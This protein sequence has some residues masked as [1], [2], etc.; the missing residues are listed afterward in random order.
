MIRILALSGSLRKDSFN[1]QLAHAVAKAS[2]QN[3]SVEIATLHG[4]PLYDGDLE[5]SGGIPEV[6][7]ALK[8][9]IIASDGL[10]LVT[11]EYNNGI[12]GVMKNGIDW[13]SRANAREIFAQR[14]V[15]II[16]ATPGGWGTISA[17]TAWLP[18]LRSLNTVLYTGQR[19]M[20]SQAK[21]TFDDGKIIDSKVE[22]LLTG[23]LEGFTKF[24]QTQGVQAQ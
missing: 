7:L 21:N 8:E 1:T 24:I 17:Q 4:I 14:A 18:V 13:L 23:F 15:A 6:V 10:L 16:G 9:K 12:P 2:P 19:L 3:V 22:N 11:P 20:I 5:V